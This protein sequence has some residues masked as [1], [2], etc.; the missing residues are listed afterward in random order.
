M[1]VGVF[2]W[3]FGIRLSHIGFSKP[4][5][6]KEVFLGLDG[7]VLLVSVGFKVLDRNGG[8]TTDFYFRFS[9]D[10]YFWRAG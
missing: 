9:P 10:R 1:V 3:Y 4:G 5:G 7:V 6:G 8:H 2:G